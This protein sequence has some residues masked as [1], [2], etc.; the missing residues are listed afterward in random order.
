MRYMVIRTENLTKFFGRQAAVRNLTLDVEP[1]EIFGFLGSTGAGKSTV[2][3]MLLDIVRPS[4]GRALVLGLDSRR[5]GLEI[6]KKVGYL[7]SAFSANPG[8]TGAALLRYLEQLRGGVDYDDV[9]QLAE[10][11]KADLDTPFGLLKPAER[12]KIGIIQAFMHRP[13]L[14]ILDEPTRLL[15][16][17]TQDAFSRLAQQ[18]RAEGR[19]I[20]FTSTSLTEMERLCDRTAIIHHGE[21]IAIER[22]VQLRSRALRHVEMRFAGP[23]AAETFSRLPNLKDL[24]LE[25]NTVRC[26]I[27]GDPDALIKA[28]SQFRVTNF[29]SQTPS[30][31]EVLLQYYGVGQNAA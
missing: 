3:R 13:E 28:V 22:G 21:L 31:E 14:L 16:P 9:V 19:T 23:I 24:R 18:A 20:F 30:L 17:H 26:T 12:Q 1:G 8:T 6:R 25:D 27:L 7:P 15:D 11:L 29:I 2:V 5:N 10:Q 4:V